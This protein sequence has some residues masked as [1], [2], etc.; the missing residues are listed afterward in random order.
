MFYIQILRLF[1]TASCW[2]IFKSRNMLLLFK[3]TVYSIDELLF[4]VY[5]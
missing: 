4:Y 2:L 5:I 3:Y 1:F